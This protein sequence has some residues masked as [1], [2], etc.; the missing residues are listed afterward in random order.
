[1]NFFKL[2]VTTLLGV[3]ILSGCAGQLVQYETDSKMLSLRIKDKVRHEVK[4][5]D[6]K[7]LPYG[8]QCS[9][10][11]FTLV[12]HNI[13]KYGTLLIQHLGVK[14]GCAW[15]QSPTGY[16]VDTMKRAF[17]AKEAKLLNKKNMNQY[18]FFEYRLDD[19]IN[20]SLIE[21]W[22]ARE[23]TFI[24]DSDGVLSKEL[25]EKLALN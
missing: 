9:D 11:D 17:K 3:F 23:N 13:P 10:G 15:H 8:G 5:V 22:G 24:I 7:Y 19:R 25:Q 12:E 16:F 2:L 21:L 4:F 6:P 1:M 18:T 14:G 20:V